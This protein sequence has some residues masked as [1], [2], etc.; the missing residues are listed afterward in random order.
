ML[1]LLLLLLLPHSA[2][3]MMHDTAFPFSVLERLQMA[4]WLKEE[5]AKQFR[6]GDFEQAAERYNVQTIF[7]LFGSEWLISGARQ[8]CSLCP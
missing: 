6:A 8:L 5:G 2:L 7:C 4:S 1:L 3:I